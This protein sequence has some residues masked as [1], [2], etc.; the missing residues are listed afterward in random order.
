MKLRFRKDSLRLRL[1]QKEVAG[2]ASGAALEEQVHFPGDTSMSYIL[3]PSGQAV[4]NATFRQGTITVSVPHSQC[5]DWAVSSDTGIYFELA[6]NG[7]SLRVAI[8]KDLECIEGPEEER[9]PDAF[10]RSDGK[11]C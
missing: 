10:P 5:S 8:E 4:P 6:A 1:N 7:S 11:G 3:E 9:D 2:L